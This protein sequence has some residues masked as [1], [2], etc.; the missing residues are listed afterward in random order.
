MSELEVR[1]DFS[2]TFDELIPDRALL[3]AA[4]FSCLDDPGAELALEEDPPPTAASLA[5]LLA[6]IWTL[7]ALLEMI[8]NYWINNQKKRR[9]QDSIITQNAFLK[10]H[11]MNLVPEHSFHS[12]LTSWS[13]AIGNR[14]M[15][16]LQASV[17]AH[18]SILH[19]V[20]RYEERGTH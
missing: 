13:L 9:S 19:I 4:L 14:S 3:D 20:E 17:R 12:I 10:S 8:Q 11:S 5:S 6:R 1:G 18:I 16:N 15:C 7:V 2:A